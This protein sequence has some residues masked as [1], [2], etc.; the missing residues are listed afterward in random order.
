MGISHTLFLLLG[1]SRHHPCWKLWTS[2]YNPT[3]CHSS[4]TCSASRCRRPRRSLQNF[5]CRKIGAHLEVN[6]AGL[7]LDLVD[8]VRHLNVSGV[9]ARPP[10]SGLDKHHQT[11]GLM[12]S[13][14]QR[15]VGD[16]ELG[17]ALDLFQSMS[18]V[19]WGEKKRI[20]RG[21]CNV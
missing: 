15:R 5:Q 6:V 19:K 13:Y 18:N 21:R 7:C 3:P 1:Y 14:L 20:S 4:V 2:L 11:V 16:P 10:H 9:V 8:D 12:S 17:S